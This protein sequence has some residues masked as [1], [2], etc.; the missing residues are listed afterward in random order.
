MFLLPCLALGVALAIALGGEVSRVLQVQFRAPG[1][2]PAALG[3]QVFSTA[4]A[5][6]ELSGTPAGLV[7]AGSY[8]LLVAFVLSNLRLRGLWPV[9][10][11]IGLN[12]AAIAVNG[13]SMPL[14]S[15]AAQAADLGDSAGSNV[16]EAADRLWFLGD[17]FALPETLPLSNVFS[18]G[19]LLIGFGMAAFVIHVSLSGGDSEPVVSPERLVAPLKVAPYRRLALGKLA[20][21][22]GDWL[23]LAALIGWLYGE[24]SSTGHVAA[25]LL[26]RLAPPILGGTVAALLVD[27]LPKR[28]LLIGVE[29]A[30][31]V[32]VAVALAGVI[33]GELAVV[34]AALAASGCLA[35]LSSAAVPALV[36]SL[37][38]DEQLPAANAGLEIAKDGA[39]AMGA[40]TAGL[41][42]VSVGASVALAVDLGTF[43]VATLLYLGVRSPEPIALDDAEERWTSGV[44]HVFSRRRLLVLLTSFATATLA[45]GL[46][47][48][49]L[50]RFFDTESG[51]GPSAYGFGMAALSVGL[52][53]GEA[54]TGFSRV[55][56]TAGRW[57]GAALLVMAGLF[58]LL[59][60][61]EHLPTALLLLALIGFVDGTT[62]VL[63]D[64]VAQRESDPRYLGSVFGFGSALMATTMTAA[65]VVAPIAND[66]F[67][68]DQIILAAG[69]FLAAA[70]VI[71]IVGMRGAGRV[72][73]R[74]V[75]ESPVPQPA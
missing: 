22:F 18:I 64:T 7:H 28:N 12:A 38:P 5:G 61:T 45:T 55:G 6:D 20:S 58:G 37:L 75:D 47:S 59:G 53:L 60:L 74:E 41:A 50:P 42:L 48:A 33:S 57:I 16:S 67:G 32:A 40:A 63:F 46:T 56:P 21:Q 4:T 36:P 70:G 69:A 9:F 62:D 25:L 39:M 43:A 35:A 34:Y 68:A 8:L 1:L 17:V 19:D 44:R 66:L 30:R 11:G 65:F 73:A 27:R 24:T 49:T 23:T 3:L 13:G 10:A 51:A 54:V 2:V 29:A 52:L 71:G 72:T 31:G 26:V 14:S 15:A